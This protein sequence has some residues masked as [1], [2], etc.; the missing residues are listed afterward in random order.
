M[1]K[2]GGRA[3]EQ[4][5]KRGSSAQ[6]QNCMHT[7]HR[8]S[9]HLSNTRH[10]RGVRVKRS[11]LGSEVQA[12]ILGSSYAEYPQ[13]KV[14]R[15]RLQPEAAQAEARIAQHALRNALAETSIHM[16]SQTPRQIRLGRLL[17]PSSLARQ[18]HTSQRRI[19]LHLHNVGVGQL[20]HGDRAIG[21]RV[22][23]CSIAR[24]SSRR[25][26][27]ARVIKVPSFGSCT[28]SPSSILKTCLWRGFF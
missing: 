24:T 21:V 7:N 10:W 1:C 8:F 5:G 12:V 6:T 13:D 20:I 28:H 25:I 26:C 4:T 2:A 23:A 11:R 14:E 9:R 15:C 18:A 3:C 19:S 17:P 27:G 16:H 22:P